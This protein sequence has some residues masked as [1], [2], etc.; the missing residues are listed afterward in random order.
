MFD[1][2]GQLSAR[3]FPHPVHSCYV[4]C[5][6]SNLAGVYNQPLAPPRHPHLYPF[7]QLSNQRGQ[8]SLHLTLQHTGQSII[9]PNPA[10]FI[11]EMSGALR[12]GL[13]GLPSAPVKK[14][15]LSSVFL[16]F[17]KLVRRNPFLS[18][19]VIPRFSWALWPVS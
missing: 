11:R 18:S 19:F 2:C 3:T 5:L 6:S 8:V 7:C 15:L 10:A 1:S 13:E 12:G 9:L 16:P 4:L 14:T 17:L